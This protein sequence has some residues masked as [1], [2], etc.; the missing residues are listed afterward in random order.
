MYLFIK[1]NQQKIGSTLVSLTWL[2]FN[3]MSTKW[4]ILTFLGNYCYQCADSKT[5]GSCQTYIKTMGRARYYIENPPTSDDETYEKKK[6]LYNLFVKNCTSYH[7]GN[8]NDTLCVIETFEYRGKRRVNLFAQHHVQSQ[9][10]ESFWPKFYPRGPTKLL[11]HL[12]LQCEMIRK[13]FKFYCFLDIIAYNGVTYAS[14]IVKKSLSHL[15]IF[16]NV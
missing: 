7:Q 5:G 16:W 11:L 10:L 6:D 12:V 3:N 15:L 9:L 13:Q 14:Y 1:K 4:L 8:P 2:D